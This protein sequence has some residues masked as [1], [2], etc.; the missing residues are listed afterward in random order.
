MQ[1]HGNYC[2]PG[3]S[4]G[5]YQNSVVSTVEAIDD[6]DQ[7]CR[8]HDSA[9]AVGGDLF[10][11]DIKFAKDNLTNLNPKR[12]LAGALV[13][14]QGVTRVFDKFNTT[15]SNLSNQ[16]N[17]I[18][19]MVNGNGKQNLRGSTG[20]KPSLRKAK[21]NPMGASKTTQYV[22]PL[23]TGVMLNAGSAIFTKGINGGC[24]IK[25]REYVS[26]ISNSTTFLPVNFECNPGVS[27]TFPWLA[28]IAANYDKYKFMTLEYTFVPAISTATAGRVTL[29]YNYNALDP[30]PANKQQIFSIA[31]NVEAACWTPVKLVVPVPRGDR[32]VLF[33]RQGFLTTGDLKT[34]DMGSVIVATDLGANTNQIGELYVDYVVDLMYPH[35]NSFDVSEVYSTTSTQTSMWPDNGTTNVGSTVVVDSTGAAGAV[36][37]IRFGAAGRYIVTMKVNGTVL[38]S[39]T[40]TALYGTFAAQAGYATNTIINGAATGLF[41]TAYYDVVLSPTLKYAELTISVGATTVTAAYLFAARVD[42]SVFALV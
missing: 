9:Y 41:W 30:L 2:G 42:P 24:R 7:T 1:Y 35:P 5:E 22:A 29:A 3:W 27:S 6:F 20:P 21:A 13:G 40:P 19:K 17:K 26:A 36:N 10:M 28:A 8:D 31:P 4:A 38:T 25:H 11:A 32:A 39:V 12:W 34:Y 23:A 16:P 14:V 18:N 33:T 37:T 15:N